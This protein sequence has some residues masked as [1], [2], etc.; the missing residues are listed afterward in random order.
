MPS[1]S[2]KSLFYFLLPHALVVG[3]VALSF[4]AS[5]QVKPFAA[6]LEQLPWLLLAGAAWLGLNFNRGRIFI[7]ALVLASFYMMQRYLLPDIELKLGLITLSWLQLLLPGLL[8]ALALLPERSIFSPQ[9]YVLVAAAVGCFAWAQF[10]VGLGDAWLSQIFGWAPLPKHIGHPQVVVL[11]WA[12]LGL[13]MLVTLAWRRSGSH[14]TLLASTLVV[15]CLLFMPDRPLLDEL[16]LVGAGIILLLGV[17][18]DSY[19][20]AYRDELTGLKGRRALEERLTTLGRRYAIAMVDVD[21]F[22]KFNDRYGHDVGDQV[23][24]MVASQLGKT[25]GGAQVYRY[26]GEEFTLV[27]P[28]KTAKQ[29]KPHLEAMRETIAD[30]RMAL[31]TPNRPKQTKEGRKQRNSKARQ[32]RAKTVAVTVSAGVAERNDKLRQPEQVIKAADKAL[33]KAKNQGRNRVSL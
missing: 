26:G 11:A 9:G 8:L 28:G 23:L 5:D 29:A 27:F 17:L 21:H 7:L 3:A 10:G 33:Y 16:L 25:S 4:Y 14:N 6:V 31:R 19:N 20:M 18:Q 22:K 30:Y 32:P 12:A 1:L 13:V 24:K 15:G 2:V